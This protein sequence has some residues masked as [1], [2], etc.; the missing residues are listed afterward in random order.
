MC[1][2]ARAQAEAEV[3][4]LDNVLKRAQATLQRAKLKEE[5]AKRELS[6]REAAQALGGS[7]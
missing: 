3:S 6:E 5:A 1:E 7:R 2:A 4:R